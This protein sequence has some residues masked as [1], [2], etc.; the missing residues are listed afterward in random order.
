MASIRKRGNSWFVEVRKGG[1][2]PARKSFRSQAAAR[3]WAVSVESQMNEGIWADTSGLQSDLVQD[4]LY[5]YIDVANEIRPFGK[6][7]LNIVNRLAVSFKN[8]SLKELTPEVLLAYAYERRKTIKKSTLTEELSYFAQAIDMARTLW[9]LKLPSNPVRDAISV[10]GKLNLTGTSDSRD[11]RLAPGELSVLL[12]KAGSHWIRDCILIAVDS[13]MRQSEIHRMRWSDIDFEANTIF[14]RDR[15]DPKVKEGNDQTI[16]MFKGVKFALMSLHK[17]AVNDK[18]FQVKLAA[19]ISDRFALLTKQAGVE[20]LVFHDLRHEAISRMFE[21]GLSI[22]EVALVSGHKDWKQLKRY[23]QL[24]AA[25]VL[26]AYE[27]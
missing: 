18:V 22:P 4:V 17:E 7:K 11:R 10:M 3:A 5:K 25:D 9:G 20:E 27:D 15:K 19:S 2:S 1:Y 8:L 26:T 13:G 23:T 16:P 6:G 14:I 21:R 12:D 24:N